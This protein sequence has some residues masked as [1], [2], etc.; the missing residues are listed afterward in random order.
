MKITQSKRT[1]INV[2]IKLMNKGLLTKESLIKRW[3]DYPEFVAR[4]NTQ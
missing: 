4:I 2:D 1:V 3:K